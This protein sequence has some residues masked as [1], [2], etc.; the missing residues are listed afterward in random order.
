[1]PPGQLPPAGLCRVWYDGRSNGQQP[2]PTSCR[3]AEATA[4][5]NRNA[6]VIYGEDQYYGNGR[7]SYPYPS[8]R[9][10][11]PYPYPDNNTGTARV[12]GRNRVPNTN[13]PYYYPGYPSTNSRYGDVAFANGYDDGFEKGLE[14]SRDSDRYDPARHSRYRD[15]THGYESKYGTKSQYKISYRDGFQAGYDSAYRDSRRGGY[16]Y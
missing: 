5:R 7:Y 10:S 14:D 8:T 16:R 1:V 12:P 11:Y 13:D 2:R 9:D 6:R 4:A 15:A 3:E